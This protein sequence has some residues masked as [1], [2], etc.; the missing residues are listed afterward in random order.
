MAKR[1]M[2][3]KKRRRVAKAL[4]RTPLPAKFDLVEWLIFKGHAKNNKEAEGLIL[5][6]RVV[7][8]DEVVGQGQALSTV[9]LPTGQVRMSSKRAVDRHLSTD[10]RDSL[11]VLSDDEATVQVPISLEAPDAEE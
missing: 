7:A 6:R 8:N 11:R 10:L 4:R 5:D 1:S 9:M 3:D 2:D